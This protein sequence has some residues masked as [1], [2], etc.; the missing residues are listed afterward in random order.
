MLC[1][2]VFF[3]GKLYRSTSFE[4]PVLRPDQI[5]VYGAGTCISSPAEIARA[6]PAEGDRSRAISVGFLRSHVH[7]P[8]SSPALSGRTGLCSEGTSFFR[9]PYLFYAGY[10]SQTTK[11][12]PSSRDHTPASPAPCPAY[13]ALAPAASSSPA[14]ILPPSCVALAWAGRID[15]RRGD[16]RDG[17]MV[18]CALRVTHN[19]RTKR[20]STY[21]ETGRSKFSKFITKS[22]GCGEISE[23]EQAPRRASR[24]GDPP[25]LRKD[26]APAPSEC[27]VPG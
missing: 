16:I 7:A 11:N 6:I 8:L 17:M 27:L 5:A 24:Q 12:L 3:W 9:H 18:W 1:C 19:E 21:V 10:K 14:R 26:T 22:A 23:E 2:G 20:R 4:V 15:T 25:P 13:P